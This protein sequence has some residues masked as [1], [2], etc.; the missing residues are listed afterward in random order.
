VNCHGVAEVAEYTSDSASRVLS[1]IHRVE[2]AEH[3]LAEEKDGP[4][5]E[6]KVEDSIEFVE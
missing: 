2:Y 5:Y 3:R 1:D 4:Q 6:Y